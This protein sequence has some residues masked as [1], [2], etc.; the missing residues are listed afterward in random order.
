M[1]N[2]RGYGSFALGSV[3][4]SYGGHTTSEQQRSLGIG[5]GALGGTLARA[6]PVVEYTSQ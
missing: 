3:Y 5:I 6:T 2:S 4:L 1:A